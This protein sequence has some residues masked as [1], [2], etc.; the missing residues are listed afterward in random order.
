MHDNKQQQYVGGMTDGKRNGTGVEYY[1]NGQK[2]FEGA[3]AND[4][5]YGENIQV[6]NEDGTVQF[7]GTKAAPVTVEVEVVGGGETTEVT[8][9]VTEEVVT[10]E[11]KTEEVV[12]EEVATEGKTEEVVT[13]N[14]EVT[15]VVTETVETTE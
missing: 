2:K 6:F 15:E 13:E 5:P 7:E 3:W 11:V 9:V 4:E 8:E 14:V 1:A 12:T 10:E